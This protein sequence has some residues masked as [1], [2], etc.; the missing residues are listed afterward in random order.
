MHHRPRRHHPRC[1]EASSRIVLRR[2]MLD[3]PAFHLDLHN[4]RAREQM[5][6]SCSS[7]FKAAAHGVPRVLR[8]GNR[9]VF[10]FC[11]EGRAQQWK[12]GMTTAPAC[13]PD[14]WE[15]IYLS[16]LSCTRTHGSGRR[17]PIVS[18]LYTAKG[19]AGEREIPG[20]SRTVG[21]MTGMRHMFKG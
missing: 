2:Q 14:T 19:P 13:V 10:G 17:Y 12:G 9:S 16:I 7:R 3:N 1:K 18:T 4:S 6:R 20:H 5:N 11:T 8:S 15:E 21:E